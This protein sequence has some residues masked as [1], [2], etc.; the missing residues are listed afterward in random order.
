MLASPGAV[1]ELGDAAAWAFEMKWDGIRAVAVVRDGTVTLTSR[2]GVDLTPTYPELAALAECVR[3]DATV[4]GE[5]VALGAH[6]RPDFGRLQ[7]RMNL[8]KASEVERARAATPVH[9]YAF[10]LLDRDGDAVMPLPYDERRERLLETVRPH[11]PIEVPPAFDG[12]VDAALRTSRT[13]GLEGIIAKR[14]DSAYLPGARARTWLKVKHS[15]TQEVVVGGWRPG[16]GSRSH[17]VGSLLVGIPEGDKLHYVGRVSSGLSEAQFDALAATF[18]RSARTT[19]P[20]HELPA[21][22]AA[23]ANFVTPAIVGEVEF[24]EWTAS[25]KLRHPVWRG[26]RPDKSAAEVHREA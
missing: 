6:G 3:G 24:G 20:F 13:L 5:I 10:D 12:D 16:S 4:D 2:N 26:R 11:G 1:G 15:R 22:D 21:A 18:R 14:R 23:D 25:G 9:F 8:R 7:E 19:S 17:R